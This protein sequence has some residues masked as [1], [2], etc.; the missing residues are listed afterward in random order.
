[1]N[2]YILAAWL[3]SFLLGVEE[4][5][6]KLTSKHALRNPWL[7][8]F[9][10]NGIIMLF[11][12]PV[13]LANHAH[14]PTVWGN[15]I[16]AGLFYALSG[17]FYTWAIYLLDITVLSPM[18]NFRAVFSVILGVWILHQ[19]LNA[20]QYIL[21]GIIF[22]A[23]LF[24]SFDE[25]TK[26]KSFFRYPIL[27]AMIGMVVIAFYG[28]YTNKTIVDVG[29]WSAVLW[30]PVIGQ[31][32]LFLTWPKFGKDL[33]TIS[34]KQLGALSTMSVAGTT[35]MLAANYSYIGNVGIVSTILSLPFAMVM[36]FLFAVF[37]P[38]L[39]E[40][41]KMKVYATRFIAAGVMF[42]AALRLSA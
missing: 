7:M 14:L 16:I 33:R 21:I 41:H 24:A 29:Y 17:V 23:G 18:F 32:F 40:R 25:H 26:L 42:V 13:A 36:A 30:I 15:I 31:L 37:A 20:G 4:V 5:L 34:R 11:T 1:M 27:I 8:N 28:I 39:L 9:V 38:T 3:A 35:G 19:G 10:W 12:V 22:I 2:V 6:G